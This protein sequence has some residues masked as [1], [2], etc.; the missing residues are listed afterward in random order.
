MKAYVAVTTV[1]FA[2]ITVAHIWRGVVERHLVS[3]PWYILTTL[4]GAALFLRGFRLLWQPR[5]M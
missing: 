2:L 1:I 5:K 4:V 3:D